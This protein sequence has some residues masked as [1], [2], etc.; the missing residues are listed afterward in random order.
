MVVSLRSDGLT[1]DE[2]GPGP[3]T[4]VALDFGEAEEIAMQKL[5]TVFG[6]SQMGEDE[7][8]NAGPV[9]HADFEV[10]QANFTDG[11]FSG[12]VATMAQGVEFAGRGNVDLGSAPF[13]QLESRAN[14]ERVDSTLEGEITFDGSDG[15]RIGGFLD[16]EG[17]G[18]PLRSVFAGITCFYR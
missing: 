15:G 2:Q 17:E 12:Y 18:A 8:C 6:R 14:A 13:Q 1:L 16:G 10:L 11:R 9:S 3:R 5:S 4:A 7:D